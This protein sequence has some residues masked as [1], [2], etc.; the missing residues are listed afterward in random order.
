MPKDAVEMYQV[1]AAV[2]NV[3]WPELPPTRQRERRFW[4]RMLL[5]IYVELDMDERERAWPEAYAS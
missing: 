1:V 5:S 2:V 3:L 4:V